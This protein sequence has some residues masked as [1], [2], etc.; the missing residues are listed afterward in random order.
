MSSFSLQTSQNRHTDSVITFCERLL[1]A[2]FS[3]GRGMGTP[4]RTKTST[5]TLEELIG[6]LNDV[7][8]RYVPKELHVAGELSI[9]LPSPRSAVI[10][11]RKA[12]SEGLEAA[13]D[14][15]R[16]L[17]RRGVIVVSGLAEGIDTSAHKATNEEGGAYDRGSWNALRPRLPIKK[18]SPSGGH[19]APPLGHFP[20]SNGASHSAKGFC[21]SKSN[22][23]THL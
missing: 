17:A 15:A 19:Y 21:S 9:P 7:E 16:T 20:I 2:M 6:P 8:K 22:D 4:E 13:S 10:G 3:K 11:S 23:G 12:S 18:L 1:I 5:Y 14:I